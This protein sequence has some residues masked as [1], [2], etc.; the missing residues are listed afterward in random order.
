MLTLNGIYKDYTTGASSVRALND[1]TIAFKRDDFVAVLG[2]SGCGKTTLLNLVG[3]LDKYSAGDI[4]IDGKSTK[5]FSDGDWDTYRNNT[6]GFVFQNYN[7]IQH[8]SVLANVEIALTLSGVDA[9]ERRRRAEDALRSVGLDDQI[10]KRPNQL[11][12]GQ[13]QRVAIARALVNN[14]KILLADEPTGALD[15]QTSVQIMEILR[16]VSK[17]RLVIMVT[18]NRE[19][20]DEY[21]TRIINL[22][23]GRVISDTK[24]YG[25]EDSQSQTGV[26]FSQKAA[27]V[28]YSNGKNTSMSFLTALK[29]SFNNLKAK[30]LRTILVSVAGSIGIIGIALVLAI[31]SGMTAY[32]NNMQQGALAGT[33]LTISE[34]S[35]SLG[36]GTIGGVNGGANALT[37]FPSGDTITAKDLQKETMEAMSHKNVFTTEYL[38]YLNAM[39]SSWYTAIGYSYAMNINM[40]Y[41]NGQTVG[42]IDFSGAGVSSGGGISFSVGGGS[43]SA[44]SVFEIPGDKE[45][46]LKN[47]DVL[48][49]LSGHS[50]G[51]YPTSKNEV[52]FVID[53][54]N[55][56]SPQMMEALGFAASGEYKFD[57]IIGKQ[58]KVAANDIYYSAPDENGKYEPRALTEVYDDGASETLTVVGILRVKKDAASSVLSS[59]IGYTKAL[60]DYLLSQ[61][62]AA[63][64]AI[65]GAQAGADYDV[66]KGTGAPL[67]AEAKQAAL[68]SLGATGMPSAISIYPIDFDSKEKITEYLAA[69]N[70]GR[71]TEQQI[72]FVDLTEL[73]LGVMDTLVNTV[74][75]ILA[76]FAAISLVVSSIMIGIITYVS[77][78]ERTK[79]IGILRSIGARKKDISRL[80][81]AETLM[82]G[83]AAGLIGIIATLILSIPINLI[84]N[85][86]VGVQ[87]I[88]A[89]PALTAVILVL[90]SMGLTLIAGL[91]PSGMA[92]RKDPVTALRTE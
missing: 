80:F 64:S 68:K 1:V 57:D 48:A 76:A 17:E 23:D 18:H 20:A 6:I 38:D 86:L 19:L 89:L 87:N 28:K 85:A 70:N 8:I 59:G 34:T 37:E 84:I 56:V 44:A 3:G 83:F 74:A 69:Y 81:N 88:A 22:I 4:L 30:K 92:A 36:G 77:V 2:P 72:L 32:I 62:S 24:P 90:I 55:N 14:P 27:N 29:L 9:A 47:Y 50:G 66:L 35:L 39:N 45:F 58:F 43:Q 75:A 63:N 67:T 91:I 10:N 15:T 42:K 49:A 46:I 26:G 25:G 65:A 82:I 54:T 51:G 41:K 33:P 11:S 71:P 61:N 53:S 79:E 12:G 5:D 52:I 73:I 31:S 7:L 21:A 40:L 13:M 78:V 16:E 60:T